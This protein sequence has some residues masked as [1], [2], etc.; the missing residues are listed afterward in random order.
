MRRFDT[1]ATRTMAL[2]LI[3]L[4]LF[5][6]LSVWAYQVALDRE[7]ETS[8]EIRIAE[9]LLTIRR[10]LAVH[11]SDKRED[12]AHEMSGGLIDA[13]YGL[14]ALAI[15]RSD[16]VAASSLRARLISNEPDLAKSGLIIGS[17]ATSDPRHDRHGI[18]RTRATARFG[19]RH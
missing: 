18:Q 4:G 19:R 15:T 11:P 1:I 14:K 8:N 7:V 2:L 12:L 6:L 5:H 16:D 13:H 9:R 17:E 10:S 3:G